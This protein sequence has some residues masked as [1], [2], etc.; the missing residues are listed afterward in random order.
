[1]RAWDIVFKKE[2]A[3]ALRDRRSVLSM[4]LYPLVGPGL[5]ALV[6]SMTTAQFSEGRN[7]PVPVLGADRAP[8]LIAYLESRDVEVVDAPPAPLEAVRRGD[9]PTVLV[10]GPEYA[11]HRKQGRT[12][13]VQLITDDSRTGSRA[14]AGRV[15]QLLRAFDKTQGTLRLLAHGVDPSVG[16][17]L[18]VQRTDVSSPQARAAMLLNVVP[19]FVLLA[20][21]IG[22]MYVATDVTAGERERG[23]LESLLLVPVKRRAI[24][25]GKWLTSAVFSLATVVL[26][27]SAVAIV[28]PLIDTGPLGIKLGLQPLDA[29]LLL[30]AI[31]P[32]SLCVPAAQMLIASFARSFKE[33]QTYLSLTIFAPM[34]PA[35]LSAVKP[36]EAAP[37]MYPVPVLG[38]QVLLT[39][40]IRGEAA[41]WWAFVLAVL[42]GLLT[43]AL[44]VELNAWLLRQERIVMGRAS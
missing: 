1:M 15:Q 44:F 24:V 4:L 18:R 43:A 14:A 40:V 2:L 29:A 34:V 41:P 8:G 7:K 9:V 20:A 11:A 39:D 12:A 21:F 16:T 37:W 10:I 23:S 36:I 25:I 38:Q 6:L 33:A 5:L 32:L 3:D 13:V 42:G 28:M 26:T 17:P 22:G 31:V 35:M 27:F 19:M 30:A